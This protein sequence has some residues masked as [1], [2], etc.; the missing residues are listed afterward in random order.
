MVTAWRRFWS[1]TKPVV[2]TARVAKIS[3]PVRVE[4]LKQIPLGRLTTPTEVANAALFL[5]SP[6]ASYVAGQ[7]LEVNGAWRG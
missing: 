3:E 5:R 2:D 7:T 1:A 6:L 4:M